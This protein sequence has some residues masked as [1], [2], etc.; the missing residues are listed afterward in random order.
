MINFD[1]AASQMAAVW[2]MAWNRPGWQDALDRSVDGVFRSFWALALAAPFSLLGYFSLRR[3]ALHIPEL[4][5]TPLLQAPLPFSLTVEIIGYLVNW[6]AGL[7]A[8]ILFAR[9]LGAGARIADV[10]IGFNWL[11]V[12]I[13]I[14]QVIPQAVLGFAGRREI[15]G[16]LAIPSVVLVVALIWGYIRRSLGASLARSISILLFLILLGV[17]MS[18]LIEGIAGL[19]LQ[20][21]S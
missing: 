10:I 17:F 13:A 3:A 8:L 21:F 2:N 18:L 16:L 12:L 11:H 20:A 19:L 9:A 5:E 7:A 1:Y 15:A 14:A 6:G 4:R